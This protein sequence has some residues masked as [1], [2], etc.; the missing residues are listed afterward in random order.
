MRL[1]ASV[2]AAYIWLSTFLLTRAVVL[3]R[4]EEQLNIGALVL[5]FI[6]TV[7]AAW[8]LVDMFEEWWSIPSKLN[9]DNVPDEKPR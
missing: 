1:K 7:G 5:S 2:A 3:Q 4:T 6:C 8:L 9:S